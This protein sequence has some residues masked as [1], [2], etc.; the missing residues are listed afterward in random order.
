MARQDGVI[1]VTGQM[2]GISFYRTQDGYLMRKKSSVSG[3]RIKN[4]P[5]YARTR[6]NLAEFRGAMSATKVLKTAFRPLIMNVADNRMA[7]RLSQQMMKVVQADTINLRGER[8]VIDGDIELLAGFEFND[9]GRLDQTLFAPYSW[10]INRATG[11]LTITIPEF[12]AANLIAVPQGATHFKFVAGGAA[13]DFGEGTHISG[14]TDSGDQKIDT[15]PTATQVLT[16]NLFPNSTHPLFLALGIVFSQ[17]VNGT[18]YPLRNGAFN[19]LA[20]VGVDGA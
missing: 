13:I 19:A 10:T 16:V 12:T 3:E 8:N 7:N 14:T 9:I 20:L 1:K 5:T 4:D 11:V 17:E 18:Y 6:E 2:D 15:V